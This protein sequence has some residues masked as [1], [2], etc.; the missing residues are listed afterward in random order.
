M[1]SPTIEFAITGSK[2]TL[3]KLFQEIGFIPTHEITGGDYKSIWNAQNPDDVAEAREQFT[4]LTGKGYSA[5]SVLESGEKHERVSAFD[6]AQQKLIFV[7]QPKG[8]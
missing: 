1:D 8:G 4:R 3:E 2:P 7:R 6:P 5:F